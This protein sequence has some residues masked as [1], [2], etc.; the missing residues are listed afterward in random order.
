MSVDTGRSIARRGLPAARV[1]LLRLLFTTSCY[2]GAIHTTAT[3]VLAQQIDR[4]WRHR[5]N[6]LSPRGLRDPRRWQFHS[7]RIFVRPRTGPQS[8]HGLAAGS[9]RAYNLRQLCASGICTM[10]QTDGRIAVSFN[11]LSLI[12]STSCLTGPIVWGNRAT[13]HFDALSN[14]RFCLSW[15][16]HKR[17]RKL[18]FNLNIDG[19][20]PE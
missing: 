20:I 4:Q 1:G 13:K 7:R 6:K 2:E 19:Y 15:P 12:P 14:R 5:F 3:A 9:Q 18:D 16:W 10:G 8:A 17:E 11:A